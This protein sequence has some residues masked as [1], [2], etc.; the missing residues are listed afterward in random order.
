MI[1][2]PKPTVEWCILHERH[3]EIPACEVDPAM[4]EED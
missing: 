1:Y 4:Y 2:N 3:E